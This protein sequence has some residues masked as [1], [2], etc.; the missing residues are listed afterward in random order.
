VKDILQTCVLQNKYK[1]KSA[2]RQNKQREQNAALPR[3]TTDI[4]SYQAKK[5]QTTS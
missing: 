2:K 4:N 3:H 5:Q 1:Q